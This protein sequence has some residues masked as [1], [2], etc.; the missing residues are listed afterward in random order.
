MRHCPA[1]AHGATI[2]LG[3]I[4]YKT[5]E[6]GWPAS[7][8]LFECG[9]CGLLYLD[10][11][12]P[13]DALVDSYEELPSDAWDDVA[14]RRDFELARREIHRCH[15]RGRVLDIGCFRGDFLRS[16]PPEFERFGI[17]PSHAAKA[18][19]ERR[20]IR[21]LG[22]SVESCELE[23][24]FD[25]IVLMD[26]IEHLDAPTD[27]LAKISRWLAPGG[28]LIVSTG[29]TDA[30]PWRLMRLNYW[31]YIPQH[32]RFFNRRWF[33][34][35]ADRLNLKLVAT[36]HFSHSRSAYGRSFVPERWYDFLRCMVFSVTQRL[37][38]PWPRM[39]PP[40]TPTW[41]DHLLVVLKAPQ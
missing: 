34:W 41:P 20:N 29:N 14:Q 16:L 39:E 38:L 3:V 36:H 19:A 22:Q 4:R 6:N 9:Q 10:H 11:E 30:A 31:Y 18:E 21:I 1:C 32:I 24:K 33:K 37:G 12:I 7:L 13:R 2:G 27:V 5:A 8:K 40:G 26:V 23:E 15:A 35:I 25:A 28:L 17:E